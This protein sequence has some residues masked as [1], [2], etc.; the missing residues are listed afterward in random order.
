MTKKSDGTVYH[1]WKRNDG[2]VT[3]LIRQ[4]YNGHELL[5]LRIFYRDQHGKLKPT[6]KGVTIPHDQIGPLRKALRKAKK[7]LNTDAADETQPVKAEKKSERKKKSGW[8][9][10]SK[11]ER[12]P[13]E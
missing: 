7:G 8:G 3:R 10:S 1:E 6:A 4:E 12:P 11:S 2:D 9:A 5:H 13:W